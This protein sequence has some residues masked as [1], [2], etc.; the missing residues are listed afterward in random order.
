MLVDE[1]EAWHLSQVGAY[2]TDWIEDQHENANSDEEDADHQPLLSDEEVTD[3]LWEE[4]G[5]DSTANS[6]VHRLLTFDTR[7]RF[8]LSIAWEFL[9]VAP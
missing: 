1:Y 4:D 7:G 6:R 9:H 2:S 8:S 5:I 3:R